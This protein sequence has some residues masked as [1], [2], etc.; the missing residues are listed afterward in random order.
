M[1]AIIR[2][3]RRLEEVRGVHQQE[4]GPNLAE[5]LRERR[6]CRAEANGEPF[7]GGHTEGLL[8][9]QMRLYPSLTFCGWDADAPQRQTNARQGATDIRCSAS[10]PDINVSPVICSQVLVRSEE[11]RVGKERRPRWSP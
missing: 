11:R 9:T 2:R 5:L 7:E 8:M 10:R 3:L 1:K 6:R 4:E